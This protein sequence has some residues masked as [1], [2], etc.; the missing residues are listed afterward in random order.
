MLWIPER[1][2][3][4]V[5]DDSKLLLSFADGWR[6]LKLLKAKFQFVIKGH[7]LIRRWLDVSTSAGVED[8]ANTRTLSLPRKRPQGSTKRSQLLANGC[9]VLNLVLWPVFKRLIYVSFQNKPPVFR[10]LTL[11]IF[12]HCLLNAA[13]R[14]C[15]DLSKRLV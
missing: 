14:T 10:T 7:C 11:A 8:T 1:G 4:S 2:F 6:L 13:A 3:K 15:H 12:L 9:R 5:S